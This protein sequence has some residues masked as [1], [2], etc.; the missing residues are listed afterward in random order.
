MYQF[1]TEEVDTGE[2]DEMESM[3]FRQGE[4][5]GKFNRQTLLSECRKQIRPRNCSYVFKNKDIAAIQYAELRT[6][7]FVFRY[8]TE[9]S[10]LFKTKGIGPKFLDKGVFVYISFKLVSIRKRRMKS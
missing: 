10:P 2:L 4:E 6:P 9:K 3:V 8:E 7:Y 1:K 5:L